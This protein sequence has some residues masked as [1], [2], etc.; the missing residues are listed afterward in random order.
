MGPMSFSFARGVLHN[1]C[2]P[3]NV[4]L[5][6]PE[7]PWNTGNIGRTCVAAGARLHL[8]GR[9]G[10]SLSERRIK[11]S[12]MDYWKKLEL[13]RHESFDAFRCWLPPGAALRAFAAA[14]GK[15]FWEAPFG[16]DDYLLFGGESRGLPAEA[17]DACGEEVYRIPMRPEARSLN[18]SSAAAIVLYEALRPVSRNFTSAT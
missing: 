6:E 9:L 3:L 4:V 18:L 16:D 12:G 10:F 2:V 15:T 13:L 7:I 8:V 14:A 17:L 1:T 5:I 11:R